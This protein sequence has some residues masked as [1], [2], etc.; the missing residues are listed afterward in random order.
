MNLASLWRL[1]GWRKPQKLPQLGLW[2]GVPK[3]LGHQS[4]HMNG[5]G[6]YHPMVL[7]NSDLGFPMNPAKRSLLPFS[8]WF[9]YCVFTVEFLF[10]NFMEQV[11]L[12]VA[13]HTV[14]FSASAH[15]TQLTS[16]TLNLS[17]RHQLHYLCMLASA[18]ASSQ[19]HHGSVNG[20][21]IY[22]EQSSYISFVQHF[23]LVLL[24]LLQVFL[25]H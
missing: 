24:L 3:G 16:P 18:S 22:A 19:C 13:Q 23:C 10:L 7:W 6:V 2:P 20:L 21:K 9:C 1:C 4:C 12:Y 8:C 15:P 17:Q 11:G 14:E 25:C 5:E